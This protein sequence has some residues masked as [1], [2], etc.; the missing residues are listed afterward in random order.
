MLKWVNLYP[1]TAV[2]KP[3]LTNDIPCCKF[4]FQKR[5]KGRLLG[6]CTTERENYI[7]D[8]DLNPGL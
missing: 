8:R 2:F 3:A 5:K 7:L 1:L 6:S 4:S